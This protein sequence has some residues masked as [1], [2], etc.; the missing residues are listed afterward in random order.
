[1]RYVFHRHPFLLFG[2]LTVL[3]F[4][5]VEGLR[6][7]GKSETVDLLAVPMRVLIVPMYLIWLL[8][9]IVHVAIF[10][11]AGAPGPFGAVISGL[12]FVAGLAPYAYADYLLDRLRHAR[13]S[14]QSGEPRH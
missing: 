4:F 9:A 3:L 13:V 8:I 6:R 2:L 1:M 7:A 5:L 14:R 11:A 12:S 10:G